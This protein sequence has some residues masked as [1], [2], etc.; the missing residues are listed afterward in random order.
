M[1]T[2]S[3]YT[4]IP[5][6]IN[7]LFVCVTVADVVSKSEPSSSST[8]TVFVIIEGR[9]STVKCASFLTDENSDT[10]T[11]N[12]V[13]YFLKW[14]APKHVYVKQSSSFLKYGNSSN[15]SPMQ[16]TKSKVPTKSWV[17][18]T[19]EGDLIFHFPTTS[20][21]GQYWCRSISPEGEVIHVYSVF[22]RVI[23]ESHF[24]L[25]YRTKIGLISASILAFIIII[26]C[27]WRFYKKKKTQEYVKTQTQELISIPTITILD[28][29]GRKVED[30]ILWQE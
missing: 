24:D 5:L 23:R 21:T 20:L 8:S 10:G 27:A 30:E 14:T 12:S 11:N 28:V 3:T 2:I 26:V 13:V 7:I 16:N 22:V 29:H 19:A 4:V 6:L 17:E 15:I 9:T 1:E 25:G 18:S